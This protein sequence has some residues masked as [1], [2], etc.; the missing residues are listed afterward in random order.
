MNVEVMEW[1]SDGNLQSC[2]R[3][4]VEQRKFVPLAASALGNHSVVEDVKRELAAL[5]PSR[6]NLAGETEHR[7]MQQCSSM[8]GSIIAGFRMIS[9]S[10][11]LQCSDTKFSISPNGYLSIESS[12]VSLLFFSIN[13]HFK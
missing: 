1:A 5:Q 12:S 9:P 11:T 6:P 2:E 10:E 7:L 8:V 3:S 4:W 13:S